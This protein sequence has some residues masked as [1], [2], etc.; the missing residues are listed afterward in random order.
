M[1]RTN[2][3]RSVPSMPSPWRRRDP[4]SRRSS[5]AAR[6]AHAACRPSS[7]GSWWA[8]APGW[9]WR[10]WGSARSRAARVAI[11]ALQ[12]L[13]AAYLLYLAWRLWS[14]P[15]HRIDVATPPRSKFA[16]ED[17]LPGPTLALGNPKVMLFRRG[18]AYGRAPG[19]ADAASLAELLAV[20]VV[21]QPLVLG[22][23]AVAAA[24]AQRVFR[25]ATA[26]QRLNRGSATILA[27][28]AVV[29][30]R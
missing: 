6:G 22:A 11:A 12:Y 15:A 20:M 26:V 23:W 19:V 25:S 7:A 2:S 5:R 29:A 24:R 1:S 27:A 28:A 30:C 18:A 17:F 21:Q 8:T 10:R 13:G 3:A 16:L 9:C 14:A 4:A